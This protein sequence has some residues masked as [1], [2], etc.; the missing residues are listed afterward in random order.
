[1]VIEKLCIKFNQMNWHC[2]VIEYKL[3][4]FFIQYQVPIIVLNNQD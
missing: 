4:S 2:Y 1:M 3:F